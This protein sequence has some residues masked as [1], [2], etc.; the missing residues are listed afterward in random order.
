MW[1]VGFLNRN[2]AEITITS[3]TLC[4]Q[5]H[6]PDAEGR[7]VSVDNGIFILAIF[8]RHIKSVALITRAG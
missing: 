6:I 4:V 7:V 2:K 5:R 1:S 8:L 3:Q